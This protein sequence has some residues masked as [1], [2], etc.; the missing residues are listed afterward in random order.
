[1]GQISSGQREK[2]GQDPDIKRKAGRFWEP[3]W[4]KWRELLGVRAAVRD[5]SGK[6]G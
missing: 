2:H 5:K 1:M 4:I 6:I 3:G